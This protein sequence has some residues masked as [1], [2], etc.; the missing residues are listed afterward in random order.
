MYLTLEVVCV[1]IDMLNMLFLWLLPQ[2]E[3][4]MLH[5]CHIFKGCIFL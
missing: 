4:K 1:C 2:K 3:L 5:Y